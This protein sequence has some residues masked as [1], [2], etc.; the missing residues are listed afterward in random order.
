MFYF[1]SLNF[2]KSDMSIPVSRDAYEIKICRFEDVGFSLCGWARRRR[3]GG[4]GRCFARAGGAAADAGLSAAG[5]GAAGFIIGADRVVPGPADRGDFAG[6]D[7]AAGD[8]AGGWLP[9]R[10]GRSEPGRAAAVGPGGAGGGALSDGDG[11]AGAEFE[12]D[13]GSG[14]GLCEPAAGC[15]G[16]HPAPAPDGLQSRQPANHA[17]GID[18]RRRQRHRNRAGGSERSLPAGL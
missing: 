5:R 7:T 8:H 14:A 4:R 11:V 10:R 13:H 12:L 2:W 9:D 6:S 18:H 1:D 15:D 16:F 17:A 3:A